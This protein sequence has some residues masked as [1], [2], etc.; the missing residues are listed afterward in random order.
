[1]ILAFGLFSILLI[2]TMMHY[3]AGEAF[4]DEPKA[5]YATGML[6]NLGYSSVHCVHIPVSIGNV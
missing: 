4:V 5:G 6:S 1:M 3:K 2:P